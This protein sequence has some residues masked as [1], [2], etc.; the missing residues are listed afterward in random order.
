MAPS[1]DKTDMRVTGLMT[2]TRWGYGWTANRSVV[3]MAIS[4][5]RTVVDAWALFFFILLFRVGFF[6]SCIVRGAG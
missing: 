5:V 6:P 1:G 4:G 3:K 2:A